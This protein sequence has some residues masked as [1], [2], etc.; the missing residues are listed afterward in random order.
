MNWKILLSLFIIF[1]IVG[2]LMF[3][4]KAKDFKEKYLNDYISKTGDFIKNIPEK[5]TFKKVAQEDKFDILIT[6]EQS[7]ID[8]SFFNINEDNI[9][10]EIIYESISL[11]DQQ[12]STRNTDK[13]IFR[14]DQMKGTVSFE[15][16]K[17]ELSGSS[18]LIEVNNIVLSSDDGPIKFDVI[19]IPVS[20]NINGITKN[21][22]KFSDIIGLIKIGTWKPL[23][24]QE[25]KLEIEYFDGSLN[26]DEDVLSIDGRAYKAKLNNVDLSLEKE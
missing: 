15:Q 8:G 2:L 9:E 1:A 3:S 14:A 21:S 6:T 11:D 4:P 10:V 17:L 23:S 26:L 22:M 19:G 25:D 24:L 5:I 18:D 7:S 20:Y 12:I 13:V 16:G